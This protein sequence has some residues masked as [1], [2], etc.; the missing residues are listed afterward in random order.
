MSRQRSRTKKASHQTSNVRFLLESSLRMEELSP[1][2]TSKRNLPSTWSCVSAE[3]CRFLS[4]P[5]RERPSLWRLRP[6]TPLKMLRQR[7]RTKR[8]FLQTNNV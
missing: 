3:E 4:K 6:Q 5:S 2:T 8:E 7:S 1:I